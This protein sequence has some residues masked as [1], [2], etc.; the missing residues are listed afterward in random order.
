MRIRWKR[1]HCSINLR[2]SLESGHEPVLLPRVGFILRQIGTPDAE[3]LL[4]K[5]GLYSC[6]KPSPPCPRR[7]VRKPRFIARIA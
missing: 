3:E 7:R 5:L 6:K 4:A 2:T 1:N